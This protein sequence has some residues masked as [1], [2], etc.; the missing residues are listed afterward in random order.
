MERRYGK[1]NE[2]SKM[3]TKRKNKKKQKGDILTACAVNV[4]DET[5]KTL[6]E[7]FT[8]SFGCSDDTSDSVLAAGMSYCALLSIFD[9][10]SLETDKMAEKIGCWGF[11]R[12]FEDFWYD[13]TGVYEER[14]HKF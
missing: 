6:W 10:I 5:Y 11:R 3:R 13:D 2:M 14:L 4:S 1:Q 9:A 12:E 7:R 8:K